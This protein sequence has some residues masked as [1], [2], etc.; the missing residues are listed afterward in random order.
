M[1]TLPVIGE[2]LTALEL[3]DVNVSVEELKSCGMTMIKI[4]NYKGGSRLPKHRDGES[5]WLSRPATELHQNGRK[6]PDS[7]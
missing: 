1:K 7:A 3:D 6:R 2:D 4:I 5:R